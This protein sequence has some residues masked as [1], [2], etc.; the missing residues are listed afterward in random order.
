MATT[1]KVEAPEAQAEQYVL[2]GIGDTVFYW[3]GS[4]ENCDRDF[5][6]AIVTDCAEATKGFLGLSVIFPGHHNFVPREAIQHQGVAKKG[7]A[8]WTFRGEPRLA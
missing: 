3:H 7:E 8:C 2:P 6:A 5:Y 4:D 1:K